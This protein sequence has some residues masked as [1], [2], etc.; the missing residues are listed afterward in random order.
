MIAAGPSRYSGDSAVRSLD[1]FGGA[2]T[3]NRGHRALGHPA[4]AATMDIGDIV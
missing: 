2:R 4:I 1:G 3:L